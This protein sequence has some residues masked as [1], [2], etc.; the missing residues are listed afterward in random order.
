MVK[1]HLTIILLAVPLL[2][3]LTGCTGGVNG[4]GTSD[5]SQDLGTPIVRGN[6]FNDAGW[7]YMDKGQ[8]ES[9]ISQ[10]NKV[11]ADSP[12]DDEKAEA[13]NGIGW[14][15]A[16]IGQL[17]DG[18]PWFSKAIDWSNDAKVGLAAAYLQMASKSDMEQVV[19]LLY[20]KL[21]N[22]NDNF[23]F[24]PRRNIGMGNAEVH[25]MLAYAFAAL[26]EDEK[27]NHQIDHAK[28]LNPNWE[29][30]TIDQLSKVIEFLVN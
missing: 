13:N 18:V 6:A 10:F 15:K 22:E 11:L 27:A 14:A 12:T 21:G 8:H 23:K 30:T 29:N 5:Y 16:K 25:A 7:N 28:E 20:K 17:K 3:G 1:K 19:D 26:G 4:E 2:L 9:A 24:T